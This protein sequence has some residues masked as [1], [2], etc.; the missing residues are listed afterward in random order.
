M[1]GAGGFRKDDP[2]D[3]CGT[4]SDGKTAA[5]ATTI[6]AISPVATA[7]TIL[8]LFHNRRPRRHC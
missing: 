4:Q 6:P 5:A 8:S 3:D 1:L 2:A 7:S